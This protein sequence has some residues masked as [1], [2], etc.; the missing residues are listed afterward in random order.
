MSNNSNSS[1]SKNST[2]HPHPMI[3]VP[4]AMRIALREVAS[5]LLRKID[6]DEP[7]TY[8]ETV[9]LEH[10]LH[11]SSAEIIQAPISIPVV[12]TSI[13]DGFCIRYADYLSAQ[14]GDEF[15]VIGYS[16][17]GDASMR[18]EG[19]AHDASN[20]F[21]AMYVTTGAVLP[22]GF[23]SVIPIEK[24]TFKEGSGESSNDVLESIRNGHAGCISIDKGKVALAEKQWVRKAGSDLKAGTVLLHEGQTICSAQIALLAQTGIFS[25]LVRR[26][27]IV[28]VLSTGDELIDER[29]IQSGTWNKVGKIYDANRPAIMSL[30]QNF[31]ALVVDLGQASDTIESLEEK[32][33]AGLSSC[34]IVVTSG[35]VSMGEL[36]LIEN[37]LVQKLHATVK[38]GRIHMKPG[39]P[40]T[41]LTI[42]NF[43]SKNLTKFV[44]SLPGNPVSAMVCSHLFIYPIL[45]LINRGVKRHETVNEIVDCT[46]VHPEIDVVLNDD[47]KLD[48]ERPEYHRV[49]LKWDVGRSI[50]V[51]TST[52][53]QRSSCLMSMNGAT[54]LVC[55]P[56]ATDDKN[57]C[58][59]GEKHLAL[60]ISNSF[61]DIVDPQ[62]VK[63][64]RH[65]LRHSIL[66]KRKKIKVPLKIGLVLRKTVGSPEE[67][68]ERVQSIL[69]TVEIAFVD[70]VLHQERLSQ[71]LLE[72]TKGIDVLIIISNE[73][74]R[75]SNKLAAFIDSCLHK[76]SDALA[77]QMRQGAAS[78]CGLAALFEVIVG[79]INETLVCSV[80]E[81]GLVGALGKIR[82]R[83]MFHAVMITQ[84]KPYPHK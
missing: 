49:K 76:R 80:P 8:T 81:E 10:A 72:K 44:L 84:G 45:N 64:S 69:D 75:D 16:V 3:P 41:F 35:G 53:M 20:S 51:A 17:A 62:I 74:F 82:G 31:G 21:E 70:S 23:D 14:S 65:M 39:K 37:V 36:D 22:A 66:T 46:P 73:G 55:L 4:D 30:V 60:L 54:A 58:K 34:D 42:E 12:D 57:K 13:M 24:V 15:K 11:R 67:H 83:V 32:L 59:A 78:E 26:K 52:G 61:K 47:L 71:I 27:T 56:R 43:G 33:S 9:S 50:F 2:N 18:N 48:R 6:H 5:S 38:F 40:T 79:T 68:I 63:H 19:E 28:G 7:K 25:V 1:A 29:N 77:L